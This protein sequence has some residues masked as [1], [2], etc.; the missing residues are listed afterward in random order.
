MEE[1]NPC[2]KWHARFG[3]A[4]T[5]GIK[6][7]LSGMQIE[8][9]LT[10]DVCLK[11]KMVK[12]PFHGNFTPTS[13]SLEVV[14]RDLVGPISPTTN[15]G[16]R[17]FLTLVDQHT[18]F[19]H[20]ALL[21]EMSEATAKI[22]KYKKL[23]EKQTGNSIKKLVTNG[24]GEFCNKVL[25]GILANEGIQHNVAPPYT[26]QHNGLA[27]QANRTIIEMTRCMMFQRNLAPEW[28]GE[29]AITAVATTNAL[30]SL[31]KSKASPCQL[32][33]KLT[34]CPEFFKPFGCK[35]WALKPKFKREKKF[36]AI[37]WDGTL[38]GY[39]NDYS[40]YRIYWHE[41][42]QFDYTRKV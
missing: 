2:Q 7:I 38:M 1:L 36:N 23:Y 40:R 18:G 3:R 8:G 25:S 15:G 32:F 17:Y 35:A 20:I 9:S 6:T 19:I 11:G 42:C 37:S 24:G 26:P 41:D 28:W 10:C 31:S 4:S 29:A 14:H 16:C 12:S 27:E 22:V 13:A 34:P 21:R 5:T 30:P 33:L 39:A